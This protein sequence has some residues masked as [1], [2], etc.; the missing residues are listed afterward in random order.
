M[1]W[2]MEFSSLLLAES[3]ELAGVLLTDCVVCEF[4][5][6]ELVAVVVFL[7]L[8]IR[9]NPMATITITANKISRIITVEPLL[10]FL[11]I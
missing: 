8:W 11:I 4:D 3:L 9:Q 6:V 7:L 10:F 2:P 5:L 1:L